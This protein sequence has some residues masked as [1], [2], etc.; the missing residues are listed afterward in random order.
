MKKEIQIAPMLDWTDSFFR[1]F[2]RLISRHITLYTEMI[3]EK[4]IVLGNSDKLLRFEVTEH[5]LILQVGGSTPHLMAQVAK[6]AQEKGFDGININAGCPSERVFA[7][8][9][10]ACL[11][12]QPLKVA[13]CI[14]VMKNE[15]TTQRLCCPAAGYAHLGLYLRGTERGNG[16]YRPVYIPGSALWPCRGGSA[17]SYPFI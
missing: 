5:P 14:S 1:Q 15:T 11:M 7:G 13:E 8:A 6:I 16:L 10:G 2:F 12:A 17:A 4:A 9:F 3:A